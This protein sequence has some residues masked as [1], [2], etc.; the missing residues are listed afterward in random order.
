MPRDYIYFVSSLPLLAF[1]GE[2]PF[3]FEAFL[4]DCSIHLSTDEFIIAGRIFDNDIEDLHVEDETLQALIDFNRR[5]QN[6]LAFFRAERAHKDPVDYLRGP[7]LGSSFYTEA[8]HQ[9]AKH[10]NLL[11]AEKLVDRLKWDVWG[12]ITATSYFSL[13][14]IVVFGLKLKMLEKY[15]QVLRSSKG[16]EIFEELSSP[17]FLEQYLY[18]INK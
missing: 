9:T 12:D 1:E 4:R 14:N 16:E 2:L 5:F 3:F 17:E 15:Q 10:A 6:E 13:G 18:R 8:I 11:E 7:R